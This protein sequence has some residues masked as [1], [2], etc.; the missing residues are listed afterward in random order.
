METSLSVPI[1]G[2]STCF[3][4]LMSEFVSLLRN[5]VIPIFESSRT[6]VVYSLRLHTLSKEG[7]KITNLRFS[8]ISCI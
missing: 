6:M 4:L 7:E 8:A 1:I 2:R 5:Q 3:A